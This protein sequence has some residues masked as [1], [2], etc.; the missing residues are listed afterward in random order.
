MTIG[1]VAAVALGI[2]AAGCDGVSKPKFAEVVS[3][4]EA[5][6]TIRTPR[7]VCEDVVVQKKAPVKDEHRLTGKVVGGVAGGVLGHQI[8]GGSGQTV[9]TIAGAAGGAYVGNKVQK[10][11]QDKDVVTSTERRC[12]TV[13][14]TSEKLLG[15]DVAYRLD[16]KE[17]AVRLAYDPGKQ[18]PVKDGQLVLA[19]PVEAPRK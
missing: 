19:P 3:V 2:G 10:N 6:E 16:G 7:E 11:M 15:Y 8:G 18:I 14:D 9:A 4:K 5:K 1:G 17:G 12:K 13:E